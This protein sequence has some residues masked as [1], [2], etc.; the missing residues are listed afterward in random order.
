MAH[1]IAVIGAGIAGLAGAAALQQRG[2]D[3]SVIEERT[4]TSTGAAISIWPNAL[5]ALDT[6]GVGD[7]V[8]AAGGRIAAGALR[9][10]NGSW[11]RRPA[12]SKVITA[13]GEPLVVIQRSTLRDILTAAVRTGSIE[14]GLAAEQLLEHGD[15]VRIT[16]SDGS[17]RDVD[18]VIGADG[19]GSMVARHLNG[20]LPHRYAGYTAWRGIADCDMDPELSGETLG[21]G[22]ETGHVPMGSGRTY[23]FTT[24]RVPQGQ[25]APDG[26]LAYLRD[27]L[28][29]WPA[30]IPDLLAA[31]PPDAVLRNDLYD[32]KP[33]RVWASGPVLLVG[34]AA[35]PM[36]PHLGQGG[37]QGIEDAAILGVFVD[38]SADLPMAFARFEAFRRP[39]IASLV[40]E[41]AMIGRVVNLRPDFLSAIA[42]RATALVPERSFLRHLAS[43]AARSAFALPD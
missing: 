33:A 14:Y 12:A 21:P 40:R 23:W 11:L 32:R 9:W 10:R 3:V 2:Y 30:P 37:C 27:R 8:R 20:P 16:L 24:K 4:D 31:T 41:S 34:D 13:L 29:G 38:G 5:A 18:A 1:R 25:T 36:R 17:V 6:L 43:V 7:A 42:T 22:A 15:G 39:R 35:H 26:E 28:A 19:T